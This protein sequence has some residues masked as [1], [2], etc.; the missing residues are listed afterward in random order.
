MLSIVSGY[1]FI[2][3]AR[4]I[5]VSLMTT[6]TLMIVRG[7]RA[8]AAFIGFFEIIIYIIALNKV[9]N[10][11]DN[12]ANILA[13]ALGFATGN[14]M[15]SFIEEKMAL[16]NIAAQIIP[17]KNGDDLQEVLRD[18]GF[19]VTV[20]EGMGKEGTKKI[21]NVALKRKNLPKLLD[22]VNRFD[23]GAFITVMDAR[24]T[25]GGY[26]MQTHKSK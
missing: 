8:Y 24:T 11:L 20:L 21:L 19:G 7:K 26:F 18:E 3:F 1:L 25:R 15:G 9:V 13:Y 22:I 4:V 12:P 5:D 16:G 2:F 17:K 6:R 23:D 14:Y 10:N